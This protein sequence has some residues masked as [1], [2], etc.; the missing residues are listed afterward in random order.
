VDNDSAVHTMQLSEDEAVDD[1]A[2]DTNTNTNTNTRE[3]G[4]SAECRTKERLTT[5]V[6]VLL[7][8]AGDGH[9]FV[10]LLHAGGWYAAQPRRWPANERPKPPS[11]ITIPAATDAFALFLAAPK[12]NHL[13]LPHVSLYPSYLR[14]RT[15]FELLYGKYITW[16]CRNPPPTVSARP[17]THHY[18]ITNHSD[19]AAHWATDFRH[20]TPYSSGG[21]QSASPV[22]ASHRRLLFSGV[23]ISRRIAMLE[24]IFAALKHRG[25]I[26]MLESVSAALK[27]RAQ[28]LRTT[29]LFL[30]GAFLHVL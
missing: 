14:W 20:S 12:Q 22:R 6:D 24:S 9:C 13:Q 16:T 26:A 1:G 17:P 29:N 30:Q 23:I 18:P 28:S 3:T 27:H 19:M 4:A 25:R 11:P 5:Q 21:I 7:E 15:R 2:T 8:A 10:M